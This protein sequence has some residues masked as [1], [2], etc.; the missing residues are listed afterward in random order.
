M[1][2]AL[3]SVIIPTFNRFQSLTRAVASVLVQSWPNLEIIVVD[4]G[5]TDN[6]ADLMRE[7]F[8][9][10][11]RLLRLS[12]NR[13]VSYARN[14]G[15][16]LSRGSFIA[17]LDSDDLWEPEK[18]E[19]Q[20]A[21]MRADSETLISQTDEIWIRNGKRVNPCKHHQKP[22]GSIFSECLPLCVVS[23]SA[24]MMRRR[25]FAEIGLFDESLPAC[26]D[27]DLWLR[28]ACR[29][30]IPLLTEKLVVKHGGHDDQLSR[31]IPALDLYRILSLLKIFA[32]DILTPFQ[33]ISA[34]ATLERKSK[35]YLN[36]CRKR[37]R[38][39]EANDL[40]QSL[41]DLGL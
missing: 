37:G 27:Y 25:F 30:P 21:F 18:V 14:R 9:S 23:P 15:I 34:L 2:Q 4:D 8:G 35:I 24:V 17:F 28:T 31:T 36:G 39:K 41:R 11:I 7:Q 12:R 19:R 26:E 16:E 33:K 13:G 32:S 29:Y 6:S 38:I 5:S 3:V 10:R 22:S 20:L 40:E 1:T